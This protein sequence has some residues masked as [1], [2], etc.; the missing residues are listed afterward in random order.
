MKAALMLCAIIGSFLLVAN[1]PLT[2][3]WETKPSE[4][5]N[6]TGVVFKNDS[7]LEGYVNKKPFTSGIYRFSAKDSVLSFTDNGCNGAEGIYKVLFYS[8]SDSLRFKAISDSCDE[9]RNGMQRLIMGRV[10]PR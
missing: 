9:R 8:N 4:K 6:V 2:G 5:G 3:R 1:D 10:K 7:I